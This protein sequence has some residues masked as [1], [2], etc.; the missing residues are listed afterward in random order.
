MAQNL[1]AYQVAV[2][3]VNTFEKINIDKYQRECALVAVG[4]LCLLHDTL[5]EQAAVVA[6]R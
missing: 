6:T 3:I 2:V 5:I 4:T 1:I